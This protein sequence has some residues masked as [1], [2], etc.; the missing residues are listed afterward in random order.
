MQVNPQK[1]KSLIQISPLKWWAF[2]DDISLTLGHE[3]DI[4]N[5]TPPTVSVH[6]WMKRLLYYIQS[7]RSRKNKPF[8]LFSSFNILFLLEVRHNTEVKTVANFR[9]TRTLTPPSAHTQQWTHTVTTHPEHWAA[10]AAVP[11]EQL[12]YRCFFSITRFHKNISLNTNFK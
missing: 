2:S 11:G 9:F 12:G 4:L 1:K 6:F 10:N 3:H 7:I 8:P 5:H